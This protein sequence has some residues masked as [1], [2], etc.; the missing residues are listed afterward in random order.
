MGPR[1]RKQ[2]GEFLSHGWTEYGLESAQPDLQS[3][4]K[5]PGAVSLSVGLGKRFA[6]P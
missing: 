2:D 5:K 3:V 1:R 6:R 4:F